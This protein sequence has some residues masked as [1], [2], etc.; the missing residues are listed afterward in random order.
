[1]VK[2]SVIIFK[3]SL[4]ARNKSVDCKQVRLWTVN[5]WDCCEI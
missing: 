5:K 2:G 1:M 4:I 3:K